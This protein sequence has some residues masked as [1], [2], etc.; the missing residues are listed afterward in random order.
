[1]NIRRAIVWGISI[2]FG[3]ISVVGIIT[4]FGTT[5]EKFSITGA[6]LIFLTLGSFAFIWLDFFLK[7]DFLRT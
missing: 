2:I 5:L 1:M 6:L 4:L 7:T 3:I